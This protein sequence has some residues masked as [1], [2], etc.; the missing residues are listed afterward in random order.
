GLY[1][2]SQVSHA[3]AI[4]QTWDSIGIIYRHKFPTLLPY[5]KLATALGFI[6]R[7]KFPTLLL[8]HKLATAL[9]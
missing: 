2:S 5:H 8:Y 3:I 7:H 4:P 6:Y 9:E 1:L